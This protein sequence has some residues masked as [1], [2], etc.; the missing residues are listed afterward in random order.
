MTSATTSPPAAAARRLGRRTLAGERRRFDTNGRHQRIEDNAANSP[1][2]GRR[3]RRGRSG[4]N[5]RV[6]GGNGAP[7]VFGGGEAA[8]G[9]GDDL[10]NP[11]VA[12]AIDDGGCNGGATRLNQRQRRRRLGLRG[13]GARR[14]G[15]LKQ[16]WRRIE[17]SSGVQEGGGE[18]P[19]RPVTRRKDRV[20]E[21]ER[22]PIRSRI[23]HFPSRF[24]RCFQRGKGR[25]DRGDCFPSIDS[26]GEGKE[27]PDLEGDGGGLR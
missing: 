11:M 16:R 23:Q 18:G 12:T 24:S 25:G 17:E 7:A 26:A 3:R 13:G 10:A 9:D 8:D 4:G 20:R 21:R 27:R 22:N 14:D 5:L 19:R 15:R 1:S 6:D 2:N